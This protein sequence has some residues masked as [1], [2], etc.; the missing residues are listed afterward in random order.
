MVRTMRRRVVAIGTILFTLLFV[1]ALP[2]GAQQATLEC[3]AYEGLTCDGYATDEAGVITDDPSLEARINEIEQK[4]GVQVAV[5]V[6]DR[7]LGLSQLE[8]FAEEIGNSWGV[9]DAGEDD[10]VVVAV[11]VAG[12]TTYIAGG[13]GVAGRLGDPTSLADAGNSGFRNGDFDGG[14]QSMA[15]P[16]LPALATVVPRRARR[17]PGPPRAT[18]CQSCR[19]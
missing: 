3:P 8:S 18:T 14:L 13:P 19:S 16:R 1:T 9:G 17:P 5:V 2:A 12:R 15:R 11:D 6:L 4:H 7:G 10:G